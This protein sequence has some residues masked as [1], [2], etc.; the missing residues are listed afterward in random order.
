LNAAEGDQDDWAKFCKTV[1]R[2][3]NVINKVAGGGS[4]RL[5]CERKIPE[6]NQNRSNWCQNQYG[7]D[8][9]KGKGPTLSSS[10]FNPL[11]KPPFPK[12][13]RPFEADYPD[14]E[15]DESGAKLK[16]DIDGQPLDART[17][18]GRRMVGGVD[19]SL[20]DKD[21]AWLTHHFREHATEFL[22]RHWANP[23]DDRRLAKIDRNGRNQKRFIKHRVL[24]RTLD[25]MTRIP[26]DSNLEEELRQIYNDL[27]GKVGRGKVVPRGQQT[28][29]EDFGIKGGDS[30]QREY[31]REAWR[32]AIEDENYM[33]TVAPNVAARLRK[34]LRDNEFTRGWLQMNSIEPDVSAGVRAQLG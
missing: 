32:A 1:P 4:A 6:S 22:R 3:K 31:L 12:R 25:D 26:W 11:R 17:I 14:L 9:R 27:N 21:V 15:N 5:A 23:P 24:A 2:R 34:A 10:A 7:P 16:F 19:E 30:V 13:T 29:P 8:S 28:T 18:V 33:K 20:S